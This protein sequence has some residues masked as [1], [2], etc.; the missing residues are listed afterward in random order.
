MENDKSQEKWTEDVL[1]SFKGIKR[2][3]P[4]PFL[5]R[6]IIH[7]LNNEQ[8]SYFRVSAS[9][10]RQTLIALSFWFMIN[11]AGAYFYLPEE[12]QGSI[13]TVVQEYELIDEDMYYSY[14]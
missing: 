14:N 4:N 13:E 11:V 12:E 5:Y 10:Y 6:K 2:A 8:K 9:A 3:E 7:R 1:Q